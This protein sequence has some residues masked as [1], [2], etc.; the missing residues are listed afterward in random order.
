MLE[1]RTAFCLV[2]LVPQTRQPL[3]VPNRELSRHGP[4]R[5]PQTL[6]KAF[7]RPVLGLVSRHNLDLLLKQQLTK[8]FEKHRFLLKLTHVPTFFGCCSGH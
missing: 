5:L 6:V 8:G 1:G 3:R 7:M 2:A 4:P